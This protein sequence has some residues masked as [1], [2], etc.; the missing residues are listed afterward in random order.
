MIMTMMTEARNDRLAQEGIRE[1]N[2]IFQGH[3]V[4]TFLLVITLLLLEDDDI[5]IWTA[6]TSLVRP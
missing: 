1:H 5:R 6:K 2:S 3:T 4:T